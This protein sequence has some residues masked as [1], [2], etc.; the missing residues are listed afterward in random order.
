MPASGLSMG[1]HVA[2]KLSIFLALAGCL[3][4]QHLS[5]GIKGG[6]PLTYSE[7]SVTTVTVHLDSNARQFIV[8]GTAELGLPLGFSVEGDFLFH[9]YNVEN[10]GVITGSK[11]NNYNV[12]EVPVLAKLRLGKG[13]AKP[14]VD[15]G[16]EFRFSPSSG[17]TLSHAGF[18]VGGGLEFKLLLIKVSPEIRYTRWT[19]STFAGSNPDQLAVLLGVTF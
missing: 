6:Y 12:F 10:L 14:Y 15:A 19:N 5:F 11:V 7:N 3:S 9:P 2:Q 8:G 17:L 4:A 18:A 16:P 1:I 13:L